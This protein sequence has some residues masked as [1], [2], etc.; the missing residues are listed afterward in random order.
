MG[1]GRFNHY[2]V[3]DETELAESKGSNLNAN[4]DLSSNVFDIIELC[5]GLQILERL[6]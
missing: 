3:G 1:E 5:Q 4:N 6:A 2:V